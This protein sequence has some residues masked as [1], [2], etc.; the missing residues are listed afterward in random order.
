MSVRVAS[1]TNQGAPSVAQA[2]DGTPL[3]IVGAGP[4]GLTLA[5]LLARRSVPSLVL[6]A[7]SLAQARADQRWLALSRGT[8]QILEPLVALSGE[9]RAA[10]RTVIVSS[11]G[12][13]GRLVIGADEA[14]GEDLGSV[15]R[16]GDLI[17]PLA[18]AAEAEPLITVLRP[19]RVRAIRQDGASAQ[20]SIDGAPEVAA[21]LVVNAEGM[22]AHAV[23]PARQQA[24]VADVTVE[25]ATPGT[26]FERFTRDGPLALLPTPRAAEDRGRP[27]RATQRMALVWCMGSDAATRR[28][29]LPDATFMS[30]LQQ[31]FGAHNGRIVEVGRRARHALV[32]QAR[33]QLREH[34]I[35]YLG[36]AAQTLH[37]VAGQGLNLGMR[38]CVAL[39]NAVAAAL[40]GG[41]DPLTAL[42]GYEQAR[43]ADR[44]AIVRMTRTVP[45]LF[46]SRFFPVSLGRS[47]A[48]TAL[49][50]MPPLRR[51]FARALMFGVRL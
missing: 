5:L 16:Y 30:E 32:E 42:A 41:Q 8:M 24:I 13:F 33:S 3:A 7:R 37:P 46:A 23:A 25:G 15:I 17:A 4:V 20:V 40:A 18:A 27:E 45:Q 2:G 11:R 14:D 19:S 31:A 29:E 6:D 43:R 51:E 50:M 1:S 35:V 9:T 49:S 38:D 44:A 22:G 34:R 39:A 26:A 21:R 12:E 28:S 47:L 36:N 48:L 10:I